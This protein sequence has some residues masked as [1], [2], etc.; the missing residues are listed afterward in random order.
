[1]TVG[2]FRP[3]PR[4]LPATAAAAGRR[5]GGSCLPGRVAPAASAAETREAS[6]AF[7]RGACVWHVRLS[8]G[9]R[10]LLRCEEALTDP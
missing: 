6:D 2:R 10:K 5:P 4:E 8:A 7:G 9:M 3:F 1:M